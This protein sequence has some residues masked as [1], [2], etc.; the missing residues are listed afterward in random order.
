MI[1]GTVP[2]VGVATT[3]EEITGYDVTYRLNDKEDVVRMSY[4][5]GNKIPLENGELV[6]TRSDSTDN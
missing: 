5:P 2:G 4:D 6:L 1:I 3:R